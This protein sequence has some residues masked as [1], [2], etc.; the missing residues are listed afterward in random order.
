M[1]NQNSHEKHEHIKLNEIQA[2]SICG[3]DILSSVLYV[4]GLVIPIAGVWAPL[5]LLFIGLVLFI[6]KGVYREVV[7]A[8]PVNGGSYNALLNGTSKNV[9]AVAGALTILS[10]VATAVISAKS[11]VD[12]L[13]S[14]MSPI[15]DMF[16]GVSADKI[17]LFGGTVAVLAFFAIL[18]ING[19]KDSASVAMAIFIFHILT[20]SAFVV[21][22]TIYVMNNGG[23]FSQIW[24]ENVVHTGDI[25]ENIRIT[26]NSQQPLIILLLLAY[27]ASLLG[28]SG[29]ESSA[30]FVE[31]QGFGVFKK[32]L[33]NMLIGVTIFNPLIAF[34]ALNINVL[35]DIESNK[36]FLLSDEAFLV[37]GSIFKYILVIDAFLV[38]CGAVLTSFV[39]IT[40][41][42]KRMAM[43]E[44][45]PAILIKENK[46]GSSPVIIWTFFA[47][48]VSILFIT[49]GDTASI[50]GVYAIAFLTVMSMFGISNLIIK[51]NRSN[52]KKQ[53]TF[54]VWLVLIAIISTIIG[55]IGN[56]VSMDGKLNNFS[57]LAF[58]STYFVPLF[59]FVMGYVYRDHVAILLMRAT[60]GSAWAKRFYSMVTGSTY[61]VFVHHPSEIFSSLQYIKLNEAGHNVMIAHCPDEQHNE[62]CVDNHVSYDKIKSLVSTVQ[63]AGVY[64]HLRLKFH[65][66]ENMFGPKAIKEIVDKYNIPFNRVFVGSVK[67]HHE[68]NYDDLG[69]VRI[70]L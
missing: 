15:F 8:M 20:L 11:G 69:G 28:V 24:Q 38:L 37:G 17:F 67:D 58:F 33:R 56:I 30:N 35:P 49:K 25:L 27:S 54:P 60:K 2:T 29:F 59:I 34:L 68:F 9:A 18:V 47:F 57:N 23:F 63:Q 7:E 19:V 10:Y 70:I 1:E 43:D 50:G 13:S 26:T 22:G 16:S 46:K 32:T 21:L 41:L 12:Y 61:V 40:G 39:G 66:C 31:E 52:L 5:V 42:V 55:V 3:N 14:V 45:L 51:T 62:D 44:C 48:C 6:Y 36:N 65:R 4:S 64:P 53:Y